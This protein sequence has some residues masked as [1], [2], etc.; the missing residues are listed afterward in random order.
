MA[1]CTL[2]HFHCLSCKKGACD[3]LQLLHILTPYDY[4]VPRIPK[5]WH[6]QDLTHK[7]LGG[8]LNWNSLS[9]TLSNSS[10]LC[11]ARLFCRLKL[12]KPNLVL[13]E[14]LWNY[15][16]DIM[17]KELIWKHL[18]V[19]MDHPSPGYLGIPPRICYAQDL[20]HKSLWGSLNSIRNS[21]G[22]D[23]N[24]NDFHIHIGN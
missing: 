2:C 5:I 3:S 12:D 10:V 16:E 8:S 6:T 20:I 9:D 11:R 15:D 19:N 23:N 21:N 22:C 17:N 14:Q 7:A 1:V 24:P 18:T 4:C 13:I